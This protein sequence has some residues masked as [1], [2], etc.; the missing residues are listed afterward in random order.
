MNNNCNSFNDNSNSKK[1]ST[2]TIPRNALAFERR[3]RE[4]GLLRTRAATAHT[5]LLL[6]GSKH[7]VAARR[8]YEVVAVKP[9]QHLPLRKIIL[10]VEK[11]LPVKMLGGAAPP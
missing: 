10:W 3:S 8:V 2:G 5:V 9:L 7:Y 11:V 1:S 6:S 4:Q